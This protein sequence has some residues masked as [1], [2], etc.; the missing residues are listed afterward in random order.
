MNYNQYDKYNNSKVNIDSL[1]GKSKRLNG[2]VVQMVGNESTKMICSRLLEA[3]T[4][5]YIKTLKKAKDMHVN[6]PDEK[7]M[8]DILTKTHHVFVEISPDTMFNGVN[9][10]IN[11]QQKDTYPF[12]T[13][14]RLRATTR[15]VFLKLRN[16]DNK[17]VKKDFLTDLI[18]HE[19]AHTLAN[20]V[21]YRV[22]D[23]GDDFIKAEKLFKK[24][25]V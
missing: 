24:L 6:T 14:E 22:D 19:M 17:L 20:H 21:L 4:N 18:I 12:G 9:Y 11:V 23:H 10:P 2:Q 7:K 15:I 1:F 13:D 8:L 3:I 25:W 5:K 16:S